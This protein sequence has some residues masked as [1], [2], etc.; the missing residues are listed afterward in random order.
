[1]LQETGDSQGLTH[2]RPAECHGRQ[3]I[4][5]RPDHPDGVVFPSRG[6]QVD[7]HQVVSAS[8]RS[9]CNEVQQIAS[10]CVTSSRTPSFESG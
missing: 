2:S 8:S 7:M 9:V 6:L 5:A 1:M 4:Q 3:A 10:I